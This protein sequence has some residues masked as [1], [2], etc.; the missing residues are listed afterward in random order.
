MSIVFSRIL[1]DTNVLLR[2][3]EPSSTLHQTANSA[4][5]T[6]T[7]NGAILCLAPQSLYEFWVVVTRPSSARGGFGWT[8]AQAASEMQ[9]LEQTYTIL[10]E[11]LDIYREWRRLVS[12]YQTSGVAAHDARL[13]AAMKSHNIE[14]IL[15][16]NS[17]DFTRYTPENIRVLD[18][19]QVATT[20]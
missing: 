3:H 19:S 11:S 5:Q 12:T 8:P 10:S 20:S 17:K 7:K 13:V 18:P 2:Q 6:L 4:L 1:V 15:T 14:E 16:F 9:R